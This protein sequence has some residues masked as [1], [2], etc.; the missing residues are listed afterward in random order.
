[1]NM[2]NTENQPGLDHGIADK[3]VAD[4]LVGA[5]RAANEMTAVIG[6]DAQRARDAAQTLISDHPWGAAAIFGAVGLAL[7]AMLRGGR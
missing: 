2:E 4:A 6:R 7:G 5:R 1:M 3:G